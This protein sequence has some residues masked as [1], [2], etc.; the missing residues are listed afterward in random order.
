VIDYRRKYLNSLLCGNDSEAEQLEGDYEEARDQTG[1]DYEQTANAVANKKRLTREEEEELGV[2]WE[3][4]VKLCYPGRFSREPGKLET[5]EKLTSAI[6]QARDRSDV[7]TLREIAD[8]PHGFVMRQGW[9]SVNFSE[10][11]EPGQLRSTYERLQLE[12][13]AVI[14]SLNQLKAGPDYELSLVIEKKPGALDQL[15]AER[16]KLLEKEITVLET[17]ADKLAQETAGLTGEEKSV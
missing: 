1:R 4:L 14:E 7:A 2:L 8:D 15:V 13:F 12:I 3:K 6:H 16:A 10:K 9:L 11:E 17:Q 5:Y